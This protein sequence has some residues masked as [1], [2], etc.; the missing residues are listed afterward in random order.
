MDKQVARGMNKNARQYSKDRVGICPH[1]Q[2]Q[3]FDKIVFIPGHIF[4]SYERDAAAQFF[5]PLTSSQI[6]FRKIK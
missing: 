6:F 2:P 3:G 1:N 4:I 5:I